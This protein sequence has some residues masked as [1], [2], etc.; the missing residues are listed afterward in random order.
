MGEHL[1]CS[2]CINF[3]KVKNGFYCKKFQLPVYKSTL[4]RFE[5]Y[6]RLSVCLALGKALV[7]RDKNLT[8]DGN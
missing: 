1:Y 4:P 2:R 5:R 8:K 7:Q 6:P 3:E